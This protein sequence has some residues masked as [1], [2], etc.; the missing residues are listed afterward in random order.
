M[1]ILAATAAA[2]VLAILEW[3]RS[4]QRNRI[5]RMAASLLAV[6]A[7]AWWGMHP[8]AEAVEPGK[9]PTGA[10]L[11]TGSPEDNIPATSRVPEE[12]QFALPG[13]APKPG[14]VTVVPDVGYLRRH[15]PEIN[16]LHIVGAGLSEF[17]LAALDNLPVSFHHTAPPRRQAAIAFLNLPRQ[18]RVGETLEIRGRV[19]G[20]DQGERTRVVVEGPEGSTSEAII[21]GDS[22][23]SISA[24]APPAE[25]RFVWQFKIV[26]DDVHR[27]VL[28]QERLGVAVTPALPSRVLVLESSPSLETT[29]LQRWFGTIGG[30][31]ASRT[32]VGEGRYRFAGPEF[33]VVDAQLLARY[34][35]LI[36]DLRTLLSLPPEEVEAIRAAIAVNGLGLLILSRG[37]SAAVHPLVPWKI[38][39]APV[40]AESA[41]RLARLQWLGLDEPTELPV[42]VENVEAEPL[43][44]QTSLVSD[45]RGRAIVRTTRRGRGEIALGLARDTWRWRVQNQPGT[46]ARYWSFL[47]RHLARPHTP[48][49]WNITNAPG[50]PLFVHEPVELQS[51][52]NSEPPS[53]GEVIS[54]GE[55]KGVLLPL[56]QE[57]AE[58]EKWQGT[59]WPR[60]A[61]WHRVAAPGGRTHLDF[62]VHEAGEWPGLRAAHRD[63]VTER[64]A[65]LSSEAAASRPP[66]DSGVV[67]AGT[68]VCFMLFLFSSAYLWW[69]RRRVI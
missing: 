59:F 40:E 58:P 68:G 21:N 26:N 5:A 2:L 54:D 63:A 11:W 39:P 32:L 51:T 15:H 60:R 34:D 19:A 65:A 55:T 29:H 35:V 33:S 1:I 61:G 69:E 42:T 8:Q 30:S 22:S 10:T 46:F 14:S 23:F 52:G 62:F 57:T 44:E 41:T 37:E 67:R 64:F 6:A 7:L 45:S 36:T 9:A 3:R 56:A 38:D 16:R 49:R 20:L 47:L 4:D 43:G 50:T 53:P 12:Y 28:A 66:A 13:I 24:P 25:G 17:E 27:A 48:E 18:I 31:F